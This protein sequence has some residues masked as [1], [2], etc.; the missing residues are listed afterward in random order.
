MDHDE[1]L[2]TRLWIEEHDNQSSD[3]VDSY[4]YETHKIKISLSLTK[5]IESF[6][7]KN[8]L[9]RDIF[10]QAVW[11]ILL[12]RLSGTDVMYY[13]AAHLHQ[14]RSN[15]ISIT[16][17]I[18][19]IK[20]ELSER[21]TFK[22]YYNKITNQLEKSNKNNSKSANDIQYLIL[23][24]NTKKHPAH[25]KAE[26]LTLDKNK[27]PLILLVSQSGSLSLLYKSSA[28]PNKRIEFI[29]EHLVLLIERIIKKINQPL[30]TIDILT[31][32]E[33]DAILHQWCEPAY[34]FHVPELTQCFHDLF[35]EQ[36]AK[37]PE[38]TAIRHHDIEI[39]YQ[40]LNQA[41]DHLAQLL[42]GHGVKAGNKVCIFM[43]RTPTIIAVM[44]AVFKIGAI[45]IPINPKYP[46][47]RIEYV[48]T[49]SQTVCVVANNHDK[50]PASFV[51]KT[52]LVTADWNKLNFT[53]TIPAPHYISIDPESIAYIIYTSGT[54]GKP[55]GVMIR[56][57]SLT[58]LIA[59]YRGCFKV[60]ENDK[61][62][63]FASQGFDTFLCEVVPF[64]A[65]GASVHIVDDNTKLTPASFLNWLK[66]EKITLCDLPTA[67]AQMLFIMTWPT[68]LS[69]RLIK[70]GGETVTHYPSQVFPFDIWNGYGPTEMTIEA[71]FAKLYDANTDPA[72]NK[73]HQ[74][75]PIGKP[76][77]HYEAYIVD[78]HM[79][80]VPP[81]VGG[82]L[83]LGGRGIALGYLNRDDL[84][85]DK[86]IPHLIPGKTGKLY[87]TGDLARW[88]P[89]GNIEFIGRID[90]QVK[91]RGYRIELGEIESA[92]NQ[93]SDVNEAIVITK[94]TVNKDKVLI[95]Y[96]VSNLDKV[97]FLYQERCLLSVNQNKFIETITED[98][99]KDGIALSGVTE[100][101]EPGQHVK[102][103]LKLP[104][105]TESKFLSARLI[106]QQ[107]NRCGFIFVPTE[108]EKIM[109]KKSIDYYLASHNVMEMLLS[110]SAKRSLRK[111][112]KHKL[113]EYMIPTSFVTL[114]Q[115]P[116]TFSGKID[117]KSLPPPQDYEQILQKEHI[118]PK[119]P[120]EKKLGQ[121][122]MKLL[123]KSS[124]SMA[125]NFFD[126]GA[127]SLTTAELSVQVL[128]EFNISIPSKLLFDLPY[129]SILA[130]YIDSKG[131]SYKSTSAI[132]EEIE[133]DK[134]LPDNIIPTKKLSSTLK[135]P[136][137][138][139]LTGAGGFLGIYLL[140]DLLEHTDARI[141]C[142]V[143][144][145]EFDTAA[146]R[147]IA[148]IEKFGL[149]NQ[150]SLANRRIVAIPGDISFDNFGL[151]LEHYDNLTQKVDLIIHCGAQVNL[152]SS[153][154]KLRG[155][156]VQGTL[157]IIKFATKVVDKPIH[158]VSTLS[159]ACS[160][161]NNSHLAEVFPDDSCDELF[162]GYAISK[163][164][165]EHLLAEASRR[166]L[167]AAIY[168]SGYI[169][170]QANNGVTST[171][172]ALFMLIKGCIQLGCAPD[173]HEKITILPVDYVSR[174]ISAISLAHPDETAVYHIDH[175]TGIMWTDLIG[176]LNDYG[177][178]I[179]IIK[180][181]AWRDML[182]S[183]PHDNAL[184]PFLPIYLAMNDKQEMIEVSTERASRVLDELSLPYPAIDDQ[185]LNIYFDHLVEINFLPPPVAP[186]QKTTIAE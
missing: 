76:I 77:S 58:N 168:R 32:K 101:I 78:K 10:L 159:A 88:L 161:D 119:T 70:I 84:T 42:H 92:I 98:I 27:F 116:L 108:E 3:A 59:W 34:N 112:L 152:M 25:N 81:L 105:L 179:K 115:F 93:H 53:N 40:A 67:Y 117:V 166:G 129:I 144:K 173:L 110:A 45:Y 57:G 36:A 72:A 107:G 109:L 90:H 137:N 174:A 139:L 43:D 135:N 154:G 160:K 15:H 113:P 37:H 148:T 114:M 44:L 55:K 177:Y 54:T 176:W 131:A 51:E 86:F 97:R 8:R 52:L 99:S 16:P 185:L 163:W 167:P 126:L 136:Q 4:C 141:H 91:I 182:T 1:D 127:T 22:N 150:L 68:A 19:H 120:T 46:E 183:I 140:K 181:A 69:L 6:L 38:K 62:S 7:K 94:D 169:S 145:G 56:H 186:K 23:F 75:P 14:H 146:K 96:V 138:I 184:F 80:L 151:P 61:A 95:A 121:I 178:K 147:L 104:G 122:W 85:N 102:L 26:K 64:L 165:S 170:G 89:D 106:W 142:I 125:D 12:N 13:G 171:N 33:S 17:P 124:I 9:K 39:S 60:T 18:R 118:E 31:D 20:S 164:I 24:N 175:P 103:H 123:N 133:R 2:M 157:E 29:S 100:E 30:V 172:D 180:T 5:S 87:R 47:D 21:L 63:Q 156:N 66:D 11:G 130:E 153:Y 35:I 79:Q 41:S 74:P 82:E 83:L 48:L 111:A 143:R 128:N 73:Q 158:Y 149:T 155:S 134:I 28:Y 162:G 49:D 65:S 50:L 71:T 132:Q